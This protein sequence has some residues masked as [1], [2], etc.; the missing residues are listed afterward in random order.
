MK[1][2]LMQRIH[3]NSAWF[4]LSAFS[5]TLSTE[6][7]NQ[8]LNQPSNPSYQNVDQILFGFSMFLCLVL[9]PS[10][11]GMHLLVVVSRKRVLKC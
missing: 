1:S 5:S 8:L 2:Q 9:L 10:V 11:L 7:G 6:W 3:V 4:W